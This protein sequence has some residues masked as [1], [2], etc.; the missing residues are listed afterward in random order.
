MTK[1][2][3]DRHLKE[4]LNR[5]E[6]AKDKG[7]LVYMEQEDFISIAEYYHGQGNEKEAEAV[8][9]EAA[10]MYPGA[11]Q[12]LAFLS[13]MAMLVKSNLEEAR[14]LAEG[15]SDKSDPEYYYLKA[16]ILIVDNSI[17][18]ANQLLERHYYELDEEERPDYVID[19]AFLFA[20]Y[21]YLEYADKWLKRSLETDSND[22]LELKGRIALDRNQYKESESIFKRLVEEDPFNGSY[23]NKLA[24]SQLMEDHIQDAITSSEYSIAINPD[25]V[26]A[27][28]NKAN[29]LFRI[30]NYKEA[31]D[32]FERAAKQCPDDLE[33]ELYVG[34]SLAKDDRHEEAVK[35][36]DRIIELSPKG[37][38]TQKEAFM[39]AIYSLAYMGKREEVDT[40]IDR[41]LAL[42]PTDDEN[43]ILCVFEGFM[44][45]RIKKLSSAKDCFII[46]GSKATDSY[47]IMQR[48][49]LAYYECGYDSEAYSNFKRM[50]V[51]Y[52]EKEDEIV[53][54]LAMCANLLGE[55]QDYLYYLEM[56]CRLNPELT[57]EVLGDFYPAELQPEDYYQY[58][59][60]KQ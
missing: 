3:K 37:S 46:A 50:L 48:I 27:I 57:K 7:E 60:S 26:E 42:N 47:K 55:R 14:K 31:A 28:I 6:E 36:F 52:K 41:V 16:E 59:L 19:V 5:Y 4:I 34:L 24:A 44:Y 10:A 53:P 49:S 13:R 58:E 30:E 56:S 23:W 1:K 29:G 9:L 43:A 32:Y 21:D 18:E 12:P 11:L 35:H 22:Y 54:Y 51:L 25:D 45:L 8:A 17:D 38:P 15:I 39:H 20:D 40:Y 2:V 33:V